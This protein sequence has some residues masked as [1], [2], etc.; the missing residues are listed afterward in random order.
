[1]SSIP[2][3]DEQTHYSSR[4]R[5]DDL[6]ALAWPV[7]NEHALDLLRSAGEVLHPA[8]GELLWDAG[9]PYDLYLVLAGGVLLHQFATELDPRPVVA[10]L[11]VG[12]G[13][14]AA[15]LS[16]VSYT[17]WR[18]NEIVIRRGHPLP[19]SWVLPALAA[20]CLITSAVLVVLLLLT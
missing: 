20:V 13:V 1:M 19:F 3:P 16:V 9:D 14:V 8:P 10:A 2:A 6:D 15:V 11:S 17:R 7:F 5:Q 18:G 4:R 12:L